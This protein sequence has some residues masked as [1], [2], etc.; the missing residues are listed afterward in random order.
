M[1]EHKNMKNP[2]KKRGNEDNVTEC[3]MTKQL[4]N[5]TFEML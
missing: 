2:T 3:F 5:P 1:Y 4:Q